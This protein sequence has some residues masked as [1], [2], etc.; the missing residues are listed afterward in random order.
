MK[1]I[2]VARNAFAATLTSSAVAKS[3]TTSGTSRSSVTARSKTPLC[4]AA[5]TSLAHSERTPATIR[6]GRSTS[7]TAYPSCRN[8]GDQATSTPS[9]GS[10]SLA[11]SCS[12]QAAV[13]TGTVDLPTIKQRW[14]SSGA[15][16]V[17]A[18]STYVRSA[19]IPSA[20]CGVPTQMKCTSAAAAASAYEVL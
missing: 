13:P 12:T 7:S 17:T 18:C 4:A 10:A 14:R 20:R 19:P 9:V 1:L 6:L 3:V 2:L 15:R 16:L 5:S 11:T 8:S